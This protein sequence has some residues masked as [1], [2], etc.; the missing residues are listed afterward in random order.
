MRSR[1]GRLQIPSLDKTNM[2]PLENSDHAFYVLPVGEDSSWTTKPR[3]GLEVVLDTLASAAAPANHQ[4]RQ[5]GQSSGLKQFTHWSF[6][7]VGNGTDERT[8]NAGGD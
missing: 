6:Y 2:W 7:R 5:L 8:T 4:R 3:H 1:I